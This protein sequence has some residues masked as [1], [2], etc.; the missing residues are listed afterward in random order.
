MSQLN[1]RDFLKL[2]GLASLGLVVPPA[3]KQMGGALQGDKK[4]V[5][6]IVFDALSAYNIS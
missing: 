3:V 2:A 5:I 4:N 6:I 1:R